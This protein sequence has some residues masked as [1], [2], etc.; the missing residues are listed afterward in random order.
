MFG[1]SFGPVSPHPL[2]EFLRTHCSDERLARC[3]TA[4]YGRGAESI[5]AEFRHN[6]ETGEY[7]YAGDGNT[8]E[9]ALMQRYDETTDRPLNELFGAWW[10]GAFCSS[11]EH[12]VLIDNLGMGGAGALLWMVVRGCSELGELSRPAAHAAIPFVRYIR[13]RDPYPAGDMYDAVVAALEAIERL[14]PD[15]VRSERF[16]AC[17]TILRGTDD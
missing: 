14:G 1:H 16:L 4:D 11:P 12:W 8:Y 17:R 15:G 13:E 2:R 7:A 3:A 9:C 6:L 10:M 5:A